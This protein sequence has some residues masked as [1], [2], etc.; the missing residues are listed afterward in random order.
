MRGAA[1]AEQRQ[2]AA[3]AA[4]LD[5][6]DWHDPALRVHQA[7]ASVWRDSL[8]DGAAGWFACLNA[9]A[10]QAGL[11]TATSCP[12][13]FVPQAALPPGRAYEAHIAATGEVP[14]RLNLHDTFGALAWFLWPRSKAAMNAAQ[15]SAIAN[16]AA[17]TAASASRGSLRDALTLLDENGLVFAHA[18]DD[19]RAALAGHD[20]SRLFAAGSEWWQTRIAVFVVG[21]ALMEKRVAPYKALTAHAAA[22]AMPSAFFAL[23]LE[24]QQRVVDCALADAIGG[25]PGGATGGMTGG[26]RIARPR[27]LLPLPVSGMPG[28]WPDNDEAGFYDDVTVFRPL[29]RAD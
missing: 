19:A 18:D 28:W 10:V 20:W 1:G 4:A 24:R 8:R 22:L 2:A 21:H 9:A 11:R 29:R 23:P 26:T 27:D 13:R 14:T 6:I 5:A 17:A 16:A 15:A 12:L 3:L 25:T 7:R